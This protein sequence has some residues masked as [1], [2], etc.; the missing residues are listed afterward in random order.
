MN[1]NVKVFFIKDAD[2]STLIIFNTIKAI[3]VKYTFKI[4]IIIFGLGFS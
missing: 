2:P 1:I 4:L 3:N